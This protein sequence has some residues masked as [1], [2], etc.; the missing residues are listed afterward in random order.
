MSSI[1]TSAPLPL[2]APT[3]LQG[4]PIRAAIVQQARTW[5]GTPY[6]HQAR[7]KGAGVDCVGLVIGVASALGLS[8]FNT[9]C[10]G[11]VPSGRMMLELLGEHA[12]QV[13]HRAPWL[14][15]QILAL[16]FD[17]E[18]QHVAILADIAGT[19]QLS[20]I[21]AYSHA[22]NVTEHRLAEVWRARVMARYEFPGVL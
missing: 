22:G 9:H 15:G 16:R 2:P 3:P 4:I 21:H 18:P 20:M 1:I 7:C 13:D 12:I 11:R 10:Y 17:S 8:A 6:Q 14:P 19:D 5:L